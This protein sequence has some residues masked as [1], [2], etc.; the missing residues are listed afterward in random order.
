MKILMTG[1]TGFVG[2][3]LVKRFLSQGHTVHI[4]TRDV[5]QSESLFN[6]PNVKCFSWKDY[7]V[8]PPEDSFI[9]VNGV[10]HLMGEN[11]AAKRWSAH[12][13]E[14]LRS[15]RVDSAH[16][17]SLIINSL[18]TQLDFYISASAVGIYPVN[19]KKPLDENSMLGHTF[20]AEL[21]KDWEKSVELVT[22]VKRKVILRT[23]VVLDS[24]GG[25]LKKM[26]PPF[27]MGL[28]GPIG[29]GNQMMSWIHR[30]DL[31]DIYYQASVNNE[32]QGIFNAVAPNPVNNFDFTKALGSALHRPTLI[33]VPEL[34]LKIAFGEMSGVILDSQEV[35]PTRLIEKKFDFKY[36]TIQT[37]LNEIFHVVQH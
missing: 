19:G 37:C 4:L 28:G 3:E 35:L 15:S 36:P 34:P 7:K 13:K 6:N 11:I 24:G 16:S 29:D 23:G 10:I 31:V 27:K 2:T 5:S 22:N 14:I 20:L 30:D 33:P 26:L 18:P 12:Q 17:L 9:G 8:S 32:M 21:C 25:A 1:A